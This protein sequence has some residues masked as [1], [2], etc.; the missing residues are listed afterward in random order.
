ME[1]RTTRIAALALLV[2]G[3][4]F[5]SPSKASEASGDE[6]QAFDAAIA[7]LC[8][9]RLVLLGEDAGHGA[10]S[11]V[12][13]KGRITRALVERCGF[14]AV[15]FESPLYEFLH[16]EERLAAG[17]A[18][19]ELL[20]DA[21]GALW[22][23][24]V[25]FEPTLAWLWPQIQAGSLDVRGLDI[26]VGGLTQHYSAQALPARLARHAG[27][28]RATCERRIARLTR[29]EFDATH[30]F[31]DRFR[32]RLRACLATIQ[33]QLA[34]GPN[35]LSS[36]ATQRMSWAL[37]R[38]LDMDSHDSFNL[39]EDAMA[40]NVAWHQ[41][42]APVS[43]VVVWTATRHALKGVLADQPERIPLGMRL[44]PAFGPA[45]ASIGFTAVSGHH[46]RPG[47]APLI[48]SPPGPGMLEAT[49]QVS[50]SSVFLDA[51]R[52]RPAGVLESRVV[53]YT[54]PTAADWSTLLDGIW[55]LPL[56]NPLHR[57][58]DV[59]TPLVPPPPLL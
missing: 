2:L 1:S 45:L 46:G 18:T 6:S 42:R 5:F 15:Y 10:G 48:V 22:A 50:R 55:I 35:T 57:A 44:A 49:T 54:R 7:M 52:L 43:R 23:G 53:G 29:W 25:E 51:A 47:R 41:A 14:S 8:D 20:A 4:V 32:T 28:A 38:A 21:V 39:R 3:A 58:M 17:H 16:L 27:R 33:T 36:D 34:A 56:E 37:M 31:D 12:A 9:K 26:Q 13:L 24:T 30:P 11:T 40:R 59:E 19:P